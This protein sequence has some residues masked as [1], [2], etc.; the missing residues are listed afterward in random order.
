MQFKEKRL[1]IINLS[2]DYEFLEDTI[3]NVGAM[4]ESQIVETP[5][6]I[7]WI[8]TRSCYLYDGTKVNNLTKNKIAYKNWKDSESSWEIS[9]KYG[10]S[11]GYLKKEDKLI[12]Y[13]A[14]TSIEKI[15]EKEGYADTYYESGNDVIN[16]A[17]LRKLA[18]QYD[19]KTKSWVN[20]TYFPENDDNQE[21]IFSEV[22]GRP[23]VPTPNN[24]VTNFQYD[25]NGDMICAIKPYDI[26]LSWNDN[27]SKTPGSSTL[28]SDSGFDPSKD[29]RTNRDFRIVTKDYDFGATSVNKK[30][31]KVYVS[32]K[33][34]D[35]ESSKVG[36]RLQMQDFYSSS[37][38]GVYYA[39]DGKNTWTEFSP[40]S[41]INY[42][43]KGLISSDAEN[44]TTL[45][46]DISLTENQWDLASTT[47]IKEGYIL[48]V[49]DND[50]DEQVYVKSI[51]GNTVTVSR[52]YNNTQVNSYSDGDTVYIST[53]DWITAEL[54]P[55]SSINNIKSLKLKFETKHVTA[56]DANLVFRSTNDSNGVPAGFMI[57]DISVIYRMKNV[58]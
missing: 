35:L 32:F 49:G 11:I 36:K 18:Y 2:E 46:E 1:F 6:G 47:N 58:K 56:L 28:I 41:S 53:G 15:L 50:R 24:M 48:R 42:G 55:I 9:E 13:G 3:E 19:F 33:S 34:T 7:A 4:Q 27:P 10:A 44:T 30:I 43:T 26:M 16:K 45:S 25:E 54:K 5:Y 39:V 31:Y 14:T 38:V 23:R 51:S 37:N 8:N 17:Y 29:N 20:L 52:R 57:N 12:V 21:L 40:V 22:E